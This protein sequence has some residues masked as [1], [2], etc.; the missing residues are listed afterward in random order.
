MFMVLWNASA[1]DGY[2]AFWGLAHENNYLYLC[3]NTFVNIIQ[4]EPEPSIWKAVELKY[5][6]IL[7]DTN[8]L[9]LRKYEL[10]SINN[11][12]N[13]LQSI[14]WWSSSWK[15]PLLTVVCYL[16]AL[17]NKR[18]SKTWLVHPSSPHFWL[19]C[20]FFQKIRNI[21]LHHLVALSGCNT[22]FEGKK[23]ELSQLEYSG[24]MQLFQKNCDME[25]TYVN[26]LLARKTYQSSILVQDVPFLTI[27]NHTT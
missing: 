18:S 1:K 11:L 17:M 25:K 2:C 24:E 23:W 12:N 10:N 13:T 21:I 26:A 14:L 20:K 22:R 7:Y 27:V 5:K 15:L 3:G 4:L 19:R 8:Q 16:E 6:Y 9:Q